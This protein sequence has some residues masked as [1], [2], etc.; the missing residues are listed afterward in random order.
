MDAVVCHHPLFL[1]PHTLAAAYTRLVR[2]IRG[3]SCA[4]LGWRA[5]EMGWQQNHH[6]NKESEPHPAV[7]LGYQ[8]LLPLHTTAK[9][10][11]KKALTDLLDEHAHGMTTSTPTAGTLPEHRSRVQWMSFGC[12]IL[13]QT[14]SEN[15]PA[16]PSTLLPLY[17][18]ARDFHVLQ[19]NAL[20]SPQVLRSKENVPR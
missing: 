6:W 19:C 14:H 5:A 12:A 7:Q 11:S 9:E 2:D 16:P 20:H 8:P 4:V 13:L 17:S 3:Q 10:E 15:Y 1:L 18:K